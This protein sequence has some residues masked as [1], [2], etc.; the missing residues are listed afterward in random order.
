[1]VELMR[2]KL[3]EDSAGQSDCS[4]V[5]AVGKVPAPD[6]GHRE[7]AMIAVAA[8]ITLGETGQPLWQMPPTCNSMVVVDDHS[9]TYLYTTV[10]VLLSLPLCSKLAGQASQVPAQVAAQAGPADGQGGGQ[11]TLLAGCCS[12]C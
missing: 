6:C 10:L 11:D 4:L 5:T 1:M 2:F 8:V 12:L 7:S 9:S 3:I